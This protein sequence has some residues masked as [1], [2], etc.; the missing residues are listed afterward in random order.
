MD[1][2]KPFSALSNGDILDVEIEEYG[3]D[4]VGLAIYEKET[5][6]QVRKCIAIRGTLPGEKV[7]VRILS[8]ATDGNLVYGSLENISLKS[9]IRIDPQC[10]SFPT[11]SGCHLRAM[12]TLSEEAYKVR[13]MRSILKTSTHLKV[14]S[15]GYVSPKFSRGDGFRCRGTYDVKDGK[16]VFSQS[17][18]EM[19]HCPA[20]TQS[21]NRLIQRV[22]RGLVLDTDGHIEK[23]RLASPVHGHGFVELIGNANLQEL[24]D[25]LLQLDDILPAEIGLAFLD[26]EI[27]T[28]VRGPESFR[29][30]IAGLNLEIGYED[31]FHA[32]DR[33]A[34]K[35]YDELGEWIEGGAH[36]LLDVG[37]GIGTISL[38]FAERFDRVVGIDV[39]RHSIQCAEHNRDENEIENI[40]FFA[41]GWE[42]A[43]RQLS[44]NEESFHT[45][46]I[47]PMHD[48]LG[49]RSMQYISKIAKREVIYVAPS[50]EAGAKD[51]EVLGGLGFK[52]EKVSAVNLHPATS[53]FV[54]LA[55]MV[56]D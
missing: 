39:N 50:P 30:P 5:L 26:D 43:L 40:E 46:T 24:E 25:I 41:G 23:V 20:H 47:N 53:H 17:M 37:C 45:I 55:K 21:M 54:M 6:T 38:L 19:S 7:R 12:S 29:V 28:T 11:C 15:I 35:L 18:V 27:R 10:D 16:L 14:P 22:E 48:P 56:R 2:R 3:L 8:E 33:P 1:K 4:G 51:L 13:S 34:E 32:T 9:K 44:M 31:W 49:E 42:K 52:L 36:N